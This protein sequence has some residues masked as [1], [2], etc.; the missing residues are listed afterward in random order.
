VNKDSPWPALGTAPRIFVSAFLFIALLQLRAGEL[1]WSTLL[2]YSNFIDPGAGHGG[3]FW[4][5]NM[6]LQLYLCTFVLCALPPVRR[7][8]REWPLRSSLC[9]LAVTALASKFIPRVWD[10]D[11][12]YNLV[13]HYMAWLFVG[14]MCTYFVRDSKWRWAASVVLVA[15]TWEL[16]KI[17]SVR[18]WVGV[19]GL[20][21]IWLSQIRLPEWL[22][23]ALSG[24]ASA[25]LYI[26][27]THETV[28]RT[29]RAV[30]PSVGHVFEILSAFTVGIVV[31]LGF[32][33]AWDFAGRRIRRAA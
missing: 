19:G 17:E 21:L 6:L 11:H 22:A 10:T 33:R 13:P 4:F 27:L 26:Y 9:A 23:R 3:S 30:A 8:L 2:F 32:D 16:V 18:V 28:F 15:L 25:S 12:L 5:I 20:A 7:A 1:T 31:W 29:L 14:G 24:L